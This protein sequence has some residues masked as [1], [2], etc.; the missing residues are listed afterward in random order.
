MTINSWSKAD[1]IV[2]LGWIPIV[3]LFF[4]AVPTIPGILLLA[5]TIFLIVYSIY[6]GWRDKILRTTTIL[7]NLAVL[8]WDIYQ[9]IPLLVLAFKVLSQNPEVLSTDLFSF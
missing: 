4:V 5:T 6:L 7:I 1:K 3:F 9:L 2:L 8:A